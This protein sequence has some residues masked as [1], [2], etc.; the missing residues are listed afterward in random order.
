MENRYYLNCYALKSW[1]NFPKFLSAS[2]QR[3]S[4]A[5]VFRFPITPFRFYDA[6]CQAKLFVSASKIFSCRLQVIGA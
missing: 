2:A 6:S 1:Q 3:N 5:Q 4:D